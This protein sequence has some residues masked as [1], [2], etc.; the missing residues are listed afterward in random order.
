MY[1]CVCAYSITCNN[2]ACMH[3]LK[4]KLYTLLYTY[5]YITILIVS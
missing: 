5:T 2:I 4:N 3:N 1:V